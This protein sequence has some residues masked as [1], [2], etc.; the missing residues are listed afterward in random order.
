MP[1]PTVVYHAYLRWLLTQNEVNSNQ[2]LA[3]HGSCSII[4]GVLTGFADLHSRRAP[5]ATCLAALGSK[6]MSTIQDPINN[7]KGC[8]GVM[9]IAP[10]GLFMDPKSVFDA[11]CEIA[12]ITHG[13]PTGYLAAGFLARIINAVIGGADLIEAVQL[14]IRALKT[15]KHHD[16]CLNAILAAIN[17]WREAPASFESVETLGKG[18]VAH[19]AAAIGIYCALTAGDDFERGIH[20]AVNHSGDSDTTGSITGNILGALLGVHSIPARYL[21]ELELI[22]VIDEISNDLFERSDRIRNRTE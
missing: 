11:G 2:L 21:K 18:R 6:E 15:Q 22:E 13:H 20:L 14:G 16:E 7:S 4:D 10:V 5:G 3:Q 12:A 19:E 17:L 8:G 1:I 9:R